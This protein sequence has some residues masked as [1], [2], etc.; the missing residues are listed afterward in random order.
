VSWTRDVLVDRIRHVA[1]AEDAL[2][3]WP[4]DVVLDYASLVHQQEWGHL[5][6]MN[7]RLRMARRVVTVGAEGIVPL[8]AL[9]AA[10][11][12][13]ER[14]VRLVDGAVG[15]LELLSIG[16]RAGDDDVRWQRLGDVLVADAVSGMVLTALVTHLPPL[17]RDLPLPAQP[18]DGPLL[19]PLVPFPDGWEMVLAYETAAH[20]LHKGAR[21]SDA[22]AVLEQKAEQ[23]R[24][25]MLARVGRERTGPMVVA[26]VDDVDVWGG[27]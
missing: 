25:R 10:G 6:D 7:P 16:L 3:D 12:R 19:E 17:V 1:A 27:V 23:L 9:D 21:E 4:V 22:A 15:L 5:L 18:A 24:Q 14:V 13:F 2:G 8:S 11:E 26:V 20:L